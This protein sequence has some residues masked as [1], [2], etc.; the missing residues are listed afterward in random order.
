MTWT[1][2][3]ILPEDLPPFDEAAGCPK[4]AGGILDVIFHDGI[5]KG[6]PCWITGVLMVRGEHLC[7]VCTRCGYKRCEATVETKPARQPELR[8]VG[9]SEGRPYEQDPLA[10]PE[11]QEPGS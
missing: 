10:G 3:I 1:T 6:F 5:T 9:A 11:D 7:R 2:E 8:V 4:C